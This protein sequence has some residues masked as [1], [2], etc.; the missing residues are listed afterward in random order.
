MSVLVYCLSSKSQSYFSVSHPA[1]KFFRSHCIYHEAHYQLR[2]Q[3]TFIFSNFGSD[4]KTIASSV[5]PLKCRSGACG[6]APLR[7]SLT[8]VAFYLGDEELPGDG[9]DKVYTFGCALRYL[10]PEIII[11]SL[12]ISFA[13]HTFCNSPQ[14]SW[15]ASALSNIKVEDKLTIAGDERFLKMGFEDLPHKL[16]MNT[17]PV[18]SLSQAYNPD[19]E[20]SPCWFLL[21]YVP[22]GKQTKAQ[23]KESIVDSTLSEA[24]KAFAAQLSGWLGYI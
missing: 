14:L 2:K 7:S 15:Y 10:R 3:N 4:L 16:G 21:R 17:M 13:Y 1:K 5:G 12:H 22:V 6:H 20:S 19:N 11:G 24:G 18:Y 9:H 8:K 23:D